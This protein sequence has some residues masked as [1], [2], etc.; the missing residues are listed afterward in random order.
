MILKIPYEFVEGIFG[1]TIAEY[2]NEI[3]AT[4]FIIGFIIYLLK[5]KVRH[6]SR[7]EEPIEYK[8]KKKFR[9]RE[10]Y[11]TGWYWDEDKRSWIPPDYIKEESQNRWRW[12]EEKRIWID[13]Y[14]EKDKK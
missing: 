5:R 3:S 7:R 14:K 4:L 13:L 9:G 2:F 1:S 10:W 8:P 11:P 6:T 12:D